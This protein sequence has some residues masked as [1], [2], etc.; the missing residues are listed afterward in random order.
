M[1]TGETAP[2]LWKTGMR[3]Y[4]STTEEL[5]HTDHS[6]IDQYTES[7]L[8]FNPATPPIPLIATE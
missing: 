1:L 5:R 4:I 8:H 7:T 3:S 2:A 6:D